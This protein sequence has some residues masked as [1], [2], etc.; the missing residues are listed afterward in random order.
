MG[1]KIE[2]GQD[3]LYKVVA[4]KVIDGEQAVYYRVLNLKTFEL[5]DI[6]A[7]R[8]LDDI[9]NGSKDIINIRSKCGIPMIVNSDDYES[10][11][12]VIITDLLDKEVLDIFEYALRKPSNN[13]DENELLIMDAYNSELNTCSPSTFEIDSTEKLFWTCKKGHTVHTEF[14]V[15]H[16][17][18]CKCPICEIEN[19][20][21]IPSLRYWAVMTDRMDILKYYDDA[22]ENDRLSD[23]ISYKSLKEVK[24]R[25][26]DRVYTHKLI[27]VT[28]GKISIGDE[29][30]SNIINLGR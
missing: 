5:Q 8:I 14:S 12:E 1:I 22:E 20:G 3:K 29:K 25:Y 19:T 16:S 23:T 7:F 17:L 26:N 4:M 6:P 13:E 9:V 24:F 28:Q 30:H 18:G 15:F 11:D 27:D 21:R 10:S 2:D